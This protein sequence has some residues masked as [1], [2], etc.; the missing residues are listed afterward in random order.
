MSNLLQAF[1]D[2]QII[3]SAPVDKP[4]PMISAKSKGHK[5]I[6]SRAQ[7]GTPLSWQQLNSANETYQHSPPT[8]PPPPER[9]VLNVQHTKIDKRCSKPKGPWVPPPPKPTHGRELALYRNTSASTTGDTMS[10]D[11]A[12]WV[13]R[14]QD[15]WRTKSSHWK[16]G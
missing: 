14:G 11:H 16:N 3:P 5:A 9:D 6:L 7:P 15:T 13:Q 4:L 12:S 1:L 2:E 8:P 10:D